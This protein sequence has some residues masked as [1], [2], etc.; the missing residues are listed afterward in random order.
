MPRANAVV[1]GVGRAILTNNLSQQLGQGELPIDHQ[2][3]LKDHLTGRYSIADNRETDPNAYPAMGG[4]PLRSR[5]Q[6]ALFRETHVFNSKWI[7]ELQVAYYRSY[8]LFT[9][10]L[11][12]QNINAMAGITGLEGLAP[13][14]NGRVPQHHH[15]ELLEL[16]WPVQQQLSQA[17]QDSLLA[18]R[19]PRLP[20]AY[21]MIR[22][23]I[24]LLPRDF[25]MR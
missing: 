11:Q 4:F 22:Q 19:R 14:S 13:E 21:V 24:P 18:V 25:A 12:G 16:Q 9:S 23:V 6:N 3:T 8:F 1:N 10:S 2:L 17:E 15:R 20:L 7:N 5:G